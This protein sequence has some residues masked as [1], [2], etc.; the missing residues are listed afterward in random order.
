MNHNSLAKDL[1]VQ[2]QEWIGQIKFVSHQY[3]TFCINP[4]V[5]KSKH[6]DIL[7]FPDDWNQ[8]LLLKE[9]EK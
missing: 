8:I 6:V 7:I 5:Y 9:S 1:W 3:I 4:D 2:Y